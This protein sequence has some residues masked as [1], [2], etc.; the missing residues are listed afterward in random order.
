MSQVITEAVTRFMDAVEERLREYRS[1]NEALRA[2]VLE[3]R[4]AVGTE[5]SAPEPV[6]GPPGERGADGVGVRSVA[7]RDGALFVLLTD[8]SEH[9]AGRVVGSD[10][11]DGAAS[12]EEI[13]AIVERRVRELDT[14]TL[15]DAYRGVYVPGEH[16][17]RGQLATWDGGLWLALEDSTAKPG[18]GD[19]WKLVTKRG[20]DGR[21]AARR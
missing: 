3:L 15:A 7:I 10:G 2:E 9:N 19:G 1:A 13:E 18:T 17:Q 5:R 20:R 16:Y 14:R 8:G 21:D 6:A 11:R 4:A 12:V